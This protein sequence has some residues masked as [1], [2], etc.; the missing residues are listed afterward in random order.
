MHGTRLIRFIRIARLIRFACA[1]AI[2]ALCGNCTRSRPS[3]G[4]GSNARELEPTSKTAKPPDARPQ[5]RIVSLSPS[6]TEALFALGAGPLVVGRSRYCNYPPAAQP[7]PIVGGYIDANLEAILGLHPTLVVAAHGP[8]A[9]SLSERLKVHSIESFFRKTETFSEIDAMIHELGA[10]I[11]E[12]QAAERVV[13]SIHDDLRAIASRVA[14]LAPPR[15][16]V[17]FGLE[18]LSVAGP[19]S[20]ADEMV[21]RAGGINAVTEGGAYPTLGVERVLALNPDV[22]LNTA[23]SGAHGGAAL[24]AHTPGWSRVRAVQNH[25]VIALSDDAVLRPGPRIAE[26]TWLVAKAIH[27]ELARANLRQ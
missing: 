8:N 16:L 12:P 13:A 14:P 24:D 20:F 11:G 15:V 25:R 19:T 7:L 22:V 18:P 9:A 26:G 23:S 5:H 1:I 10:L 4:Q 6:T 2:V 17:V 3:N 27:P 21:R